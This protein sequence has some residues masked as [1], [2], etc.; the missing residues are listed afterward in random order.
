MTVYEKVSQRG[1]NSIHAP[2]FSYQDQ[3][4]PRKH[5]RSIRNEPQKKLLVQ[6]HPWFP[7]EEH[8]FLAEW[9]AESPLHPAY[10]Y[11][12]EGVEGHESRV[13]GPC[14]FSPQLLPCIVSFVHP[15]WARFVWQKVRRKLHRSFAPLYLFLL[16]G[17]ITSTSVAA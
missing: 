6:R 2:K 11:A 16:V 7:L 12:R 14:F 5:H 13:N 9:H 1:T 3:C 4:D 8:H 17:Y 15:F 10:K